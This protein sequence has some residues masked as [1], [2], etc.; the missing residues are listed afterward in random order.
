MILHIAG[1][2]DESS[3]RWLQFLGCKRKANSS[4]ASFFS[5]IFSGGSTPE[6]FSTRRKA[7]STNVLGGQGVTVLAAF[8]WEQS[9]DV[10]SFRR[11]NPNFGHKCP[12]AKSFFTGRTAWCPSGAAERPSWEAKT[13]ETCQSGTFCLGVI[14]GCTEF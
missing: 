9:K 3:H 11:Q 10:L 12:A 13:S 8:T 14:L 6:R 2:E 7:R 5:R 4:T 1:K